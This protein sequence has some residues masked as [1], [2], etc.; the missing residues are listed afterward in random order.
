M[1]LENGELVLQC[2]DVHFRDWAKQHY[3][4]MVTTVAVRLGLKGVRWEASDDSQSASA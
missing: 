3:A 1:G 2:P 4:A